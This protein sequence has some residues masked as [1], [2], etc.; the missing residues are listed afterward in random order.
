MGY[1]GVIVIHI[2]NIYLM[3]LLDK[4]VFIGISPPLSP[5]VFKEISIY[6]RVQ[7][8]V[9]ARQHPPAGPRRLANQRFKI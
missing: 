6:P 5:G 8:H 2:R 4:S 3:R 9:R 1:P 7:T